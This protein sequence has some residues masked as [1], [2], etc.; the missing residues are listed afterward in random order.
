MNYSSM[1]VDRVL[2]NQDIPGNNEALAY[3]YCKQGESRLSE[4]EAILR[5]L[6]RQLSSKVPG[7]GLQKPTVTAYENK[8]TNGK[9][10][11]GL[12]TEQCV[13]LIVELVD[14][15]L[16]STIVVDA[17]DECNNDTRHDLFRAL[18]TIIETST[19]LVK[20]FLSS[21]NDDD[22]ELE[23]SGESNISINATDNMAD[24]ELYVRSEVER[25]IE[26]KRLLRGKIDDALK[27]LIISSLISKADGM[28]WVLTSRNLVHFADFFQI[29]SCGWSYRSK[30]FARSGLRVKSR[31]CWIISRRHSS[32]RSRKSTV[33][34]SPRRD[35][36]QL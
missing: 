21:R 13:S 24:I 32:R 6:V 3:F 29:G 7:P 11:D 36:A 5:S 4:P 19:S 15:N 25:S 26:E 17:L 14:L 23:F 20:I 2:E 28:Y 33:A 16:Q 18:R 35:R 12:G 30:R 10:D 9:F 8:T 22:I 27:E 31:I 1:V 34:Y